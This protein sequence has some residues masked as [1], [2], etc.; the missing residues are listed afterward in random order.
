MWFSGDCKLKNLVKQEFSEFWKFCISEVTTNPFRYIC[1]IS[2][3]YK[4]LAVQGRQNNW[5]YGLIVFTFE[6]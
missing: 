5:N 4:I 1:D 6:I 3:C 2:W